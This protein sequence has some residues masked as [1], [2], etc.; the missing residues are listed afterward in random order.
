[1]FN[2]RRPLDVAGLGVLDELLHPWPLDRGLAPGG[3]VGEDVAV[4]D[5]GGN[6]RIELQLRI[7]TR[8][9]HTRIA[10]ESHR[11]HSGSESPLRHRL[12][13]D[14]GKTSF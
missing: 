6:E 11:D 9:A 2:I 4:L 12:A 7:L 10:K 3:D 14:Y 1:M 8:R 5:T 13:T